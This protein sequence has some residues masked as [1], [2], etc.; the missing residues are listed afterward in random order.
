MLYNK[1]VCNIAHPS[2]SDFCVIQNSSWHFKQS[3]SLMIDL[4]VCRRLS[5][6]F[7]TIITLKTLKEIKSLFWDL[8]GP[9][10]SSWAPLWRLVVQLEVEP[11]SQR[12]QI[13]AI[14]EL[15]HY[16]DH[17]FQQKK[18][19]LQNIVT[20]TPR[21]RQMAALLKRQND[22]SHICMPPL[23][24]KPRVGCSIIL[25]PIS[26][27]NLELWIPQTTEIGVVKFGRSK[28]FKQLCQKIESKRTFLR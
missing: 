14:D 2:L 19:V 21:N 4:Y 24:F 10:C 17:V 18:T 11:L 9:Q 5:Q 12:I 25:P 7:K 26:L 3:I 1:L 8:Q 27:Q 22:I 28:G 13:H 20:W 6:W 16:M 15:I 23:Q